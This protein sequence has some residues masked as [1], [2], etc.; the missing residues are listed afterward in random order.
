MRISPINDSTSFGKLYISAD[1]K[2]HLS[3][4]SLHELRKIE[5]AKEKIKDT[6]FCHLYINKDG[7]HDIH[8]NSK[9]LHNRYWNVRF[10]HELILGDYNSFRFEFPKDNTLTI[11]AAPHHELYNDE[12]DIYN[13]KMRSQDAAIKTYEKL[14]SKEG[15]DFEAEI[16]KILDKYAIDFDKQYDKNLD[17][18]IKLK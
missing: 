15:I 5:K 3:D 13:I 4:L 14:K 16:V 17:K 1:A 11:L 9:Y 2:N 6:K 10:F 12:C 8:I 7:S 18:R